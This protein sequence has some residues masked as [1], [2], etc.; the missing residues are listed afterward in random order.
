MKNITTLQNFELPPGAVISVTRGE[1][2]NIPRLIM[3]GILNQFIMKRMKKNEDL[4][5]AEQTGQLQGGI[6]QIMTVWKDAKC[7]N[8]FRPRGFTVRCGI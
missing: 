8:R 2:F 5:Y 6:G 4:L 1:S 7:M 3:N